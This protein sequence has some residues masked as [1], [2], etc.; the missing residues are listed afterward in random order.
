MTTDSASSIACD[1]ALYELD[2][3]CDALHRAD[4]S[5]RIGTL[6]DRQRLAALR[7]KI[8]GLLRLADSRSLHAG[9]GK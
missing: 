3:W 9:I 2:Y 7:D 6:S 4:A 5:E 1:I 8:D